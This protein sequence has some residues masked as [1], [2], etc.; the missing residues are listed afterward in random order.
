[1]RQAGLLLL[2]LAATSQASGQVREERFLPTG[3]GRY[4]C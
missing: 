3:S 2:L 1:M 4:V